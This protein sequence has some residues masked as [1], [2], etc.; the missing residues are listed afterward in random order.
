[1]RKVLIL[2][3]G[4]AQTCEEALEILRQDGLTPVFQNDVP[5]SREEEILPYLDDTVEAIV[6]G[7][8]PA[9]KLVQRSAKNLKMVSIFGAGINPVVLEG[10]KEAGVTLTRTPGANSNGVADVVLG[11]MLNAARKITRAERDLRSGKWQRY[12]SPS[13]YRA[14]VGLLGFGA[15]AKAV[16]RRLQGFDARILAYDPSWDAEAAAKYGVERCDLD[17]L[18]QE[19]D[20]VSIHV[21]LTPETECMLGEREFAQMK[22]SAYLINTARGKIVDE[23]A[24]C[25][26]LEQGQI[27]GAALD[28]FWREPLP[29]EDPLLSQQNL[30]LTPHIA[31]DSLE[32]R[33]SVSVYAAKN[34]VNVLNGTSMEGKPAWLV[35]RAPGCGNSRQ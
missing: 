32:S 8:E 12:Y 28:T 20:F 29:Q 25:R 30:L 10:A 27:A 33:N 9:G 22:P 19:S 21:A 14:T 7:V 18:L 23:P 3:P 15:V 17:T 34:I 35:Y 26:A 2:T 5:I 24:L 11:L 6:V 4:F 16:A 13:L 1:M 31:A